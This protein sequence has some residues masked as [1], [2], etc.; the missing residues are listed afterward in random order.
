LRVTSG[1]RPNGMP[2]TSGRVPE[3][4]T[5]VEQVV[6][7]VARAVKGPRPQSS[8]ARTIACP[9]ANASGAPTFRCAPTLGGGRWRLTTRAM[10]GSTVIARHV[11]VVRVT[12]VATGSADPVT[13]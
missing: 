10:R 7:L 2:V 13:G 8:P 11:G 12:L 3:G 1:N 6:E 9:I 4:A 5:R